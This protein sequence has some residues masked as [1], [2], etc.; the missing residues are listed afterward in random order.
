MFRLAV[1][2]WKDGTAVPRPAAAAAAVSAPSML[3]ISLSGTSYT[4][5][6]SNY[7]QVLTQ[8]LSEMSSFFQSRLQLSVK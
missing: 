2:I 4:S 5:T 1:L 6:V 3:S 8:E 7:F